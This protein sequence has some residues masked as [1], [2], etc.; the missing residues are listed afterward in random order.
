MPIVP[1][2]GGAAFEPETI[3]VMSIALDEDCKELGLR[4]KDDPA[5][6]LVAEKI[7][8][9]AQWGIREPETLRA[10]TLKEFRPNSTNGDR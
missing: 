8:Q 10:L 5:T 2:L 4:L 9:L 1:F 3:R 6:R 7:I